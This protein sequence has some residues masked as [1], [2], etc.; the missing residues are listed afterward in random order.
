MAKRNWTV[1][2]TSIDKLIR[3]CWLNSNMWVKI[4]F[5]LLSMIP[6]FHGCKWT[7]ERIVILNMEWM[8]TVLVELMEIYTCTQVNGVETLKVLNE[9]KNFY[10]LMWKTGAF[11]W[12]LKIPKLM[13]SPCLKHPSQKKFISPFKKNHKF[14]AAH[15]SSTF[16]T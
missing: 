5:C 15:R 2:L 14:P 4:S 7:L 3:E 16:I 8:E 11:K 10:R 6:F 12:I 1:K 13:N 9:K